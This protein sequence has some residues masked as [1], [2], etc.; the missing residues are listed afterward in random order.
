[1]EPASEFTRY[2][3][4][5][6]QPYLEALFL[7]HGYHFFDPSPRRARSC[8]SRPSARTRRSSA[9][10][11]RTERRSPVSSTTGISC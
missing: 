1:M 2:V 7:D 8:R 4:D 5:L 3:H 11:S 9:G 6:C 10:E